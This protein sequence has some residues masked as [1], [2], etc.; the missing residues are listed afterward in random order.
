M[1]WSKALP[2][3]SIRPATPAMADAF[4][5][6]ARAPVCYPATWSG[7]RSYSHGDGAVTESVRAVVDWLVDGARTARRPEDVLAELCARLLAC[8]LPLHRVA[9]FVR[10]LHP[11]VM[12]R[13]FLWR[14]GEGVAVSEAAYDVLE[15]DT[16]RRSPV[17]VVFASAE[18]IRRRIEAPD[19]P[20][21]YQII[22]EMRAEGVTDYLIQPLQFTNGEVHAIS[23]TTLRPGGFTDDDIAALEAI[24][25]PLAR[26]VEVYGLRRLATTLLGTYVG[27]DAGER[28]LRG[29]IRRGDVERIDAVILLSDLRE[30]T[31]Q[32]DRLPGEAVIG[33]LNSYF[34]C[35]VPALHAHGGEVLKFVGDGLLG[36]L[37]VA[38]DPAAACR[39]ALAAAGEARAA[40]A[41]TNAERAERGEPRLRYGVALHLGE[42]LYGNIGSTGRLDFTTTGPAVNLTARLETLA[43]DLGRELVTSAAFARHC[44][45][46]LTSLGSF[47]L[48]GFREPQEVFAP[49]GDPTSGTSA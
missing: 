37:P 36:I 20:D 28:I 9:V 19:C 35:L 48:R 43:R 29:Q 31:A 40:L 32:S 25:R 46:A 1:R 15:T 11:D 14:A 23:W 7:G 17:P 24:R 10:T 5:A 44:P 47:Q 27:R 8:G 12:G 38:A 3:R 2:T 33:L 21:D 42:V 49:A 39:S 30:F 34:D 18:P 41:Q 22:E 4:L 26:V 16:Y 45:D 6:G 13:R